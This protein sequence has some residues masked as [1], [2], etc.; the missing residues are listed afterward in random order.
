MKNYIRR[1][2]SK[3]SLPKQMICK[4]FEFAD[5]NYHQNKKNK[6]RHGNFWLVQNRSLRK[7]YARSFF[8]LG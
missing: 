5:G 7:T 6:L 1:E 2:H 4:A 8:F 3:F